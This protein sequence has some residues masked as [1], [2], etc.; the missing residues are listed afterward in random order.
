[1]HAAEVVAQGGLA[2]A[3]GAHQTDALPPGH[4]EIDVSAQ[5]PR[6]TALSLVP[7]A[8]GLDQGSTLIHC[9]A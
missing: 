4:L 9:K 8:C 7:Q 6:A 1:M 5:K 3:G 2:R